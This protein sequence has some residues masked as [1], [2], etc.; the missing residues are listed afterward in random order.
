[1][2]QRGVMGE[3]KFMDFFIS[4][5]CGLFLP[6]VLFV[7]GGFF[8]FRIGRVALSP[9]GLLRSIVKKE[10]SPADGRSAFSSL[11]LALAGTLG[12][13][14]ITGVASALILGGPGC[15]FWLWVCGI[16]SSVLKFAETVLAF[17]YRE[18]SPDGA[19]H[20]GGFYYIKKGLKSPR[21]AVFFSILCIISSFFTGNMAQ[22]RSASDGVKLCFNATSV[23]VAV[24]FTL[25]ILA[26]VLFGGRKIERFTAFSVPILCVV[27]VA[28]SGAVIA[29]RHESI[30]E[31]TKIIL[32]DAFTPRAG[33][34]GLFG[35][36]SN[37]AI[38]YGI[39][40]G[41]MSNEAGC[42]TAPIAHA[43]TAGGDGIRQGHM[44]VLEVFCD[45]ILLCTLTAYAI[46]LSGAVPSGSACGLAITA[47][48]SVLGIGA[49][50]LLGIS[51]FLFALA[52]VAGWWHYGTESLLTLG[53]NKKVTL[54]YQLIFSFTA[55]AG[56]F[57]PENFIWDMSDLTISLMAIVNVTALL[58]LERECVL[59][60]K[61]KTKL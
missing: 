49:R 46:L 34:G 21:L 13:G 36:L 45:T 61:R 54:L 52:A 41:I 3:K 17:K 60:T 42:G 11:C 27:Y 30:G 24:V 38:R 40:R 28:M 7:C 22:V 57:L 37:G 47:F 43:G 4:S 14:N 44:G 8:L 50:Y 29:L 32:R 1:M 23:T 35:F 6:A 10:K 18:R 25:C 33:A 15:V 9:K 26:I 39:C 58:L 51:M 5:I 16:A 20:G 19:L 55:F 2:R 53:A 56:C 12:V 59:I 48:E 31:V